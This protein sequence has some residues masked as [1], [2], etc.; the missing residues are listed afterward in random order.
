MLSKLHTTKGA[1]IIA[2]VMA[3]IIAFTFYGSTGAMFAY[4]A[5]GDDSKAAA[6]ELEIKNVEVL[7][8]GDMQSIWRDAV[9]QGDADKGEDAS[10]WYTTYREINLRDPRIFNL[11]YTVDAET[12]GADANAYLDKVTLQYGSFDLS[13]WGGGMTLRDTANPILILKDKKIAVNADGTYTVSIAME[14]KSAWASPSNNNKKNPEKNVPWDGYYSGRQFDFGKGQSADNRSWWQAGP[15]YK[16]C[17]TYALTANVDG[18]VVA[19]TDVHI[20]PYDEMKSWIEINEYAQSIVK[21]INGSEVPI[22]D[23]DN[24]ITGTVAKG[25]VAMDEDGNLVKGDRTDSVYVEVSVLG[26]GLTDNYKDENKDFNNYSRFNPIWNVAVAADEDTVDTYLNETK[27]TMNEDPQSLVDK[28]ENAADEDIDMINVYYQNN[29]HSDEVTGTETMIKLIGDLIE[30]GKAG[31]KINYRTWT[32]EDMDYRYRDPA[33]GATAGSTH[34]VKGGYDGIFM[35]QSKRTDKYIDTKEALEKLIFVSTLC[36]NPDGKAGMRRTNRYAFDLN[37]DAVFST[38]PETIAIIKDLMKWDP[39][40]M[41]EWHGYVQSMLIE[42][43]TA[44]HDPAFDYDLL[45][46]NM[47]NLSYA[48]GLAVTASSG[49]SNFLVPWD[50]YDGGDW[51]DGGTIYAPMFSELLGCYGFTIEFPYANSDSFDANNAVNY[52]MIDELLHGTTEF[53]DGNRLNGELKDVEGN[54]YDSHKVDIKYTSMRKSTVLSKL[55]TKL[56]GINNVDAKDK[57]DKYLIDKKVVDGVKEDRIVGRS[58]PVD[59]DGNELSFFPDYIVVPVDDETQYN[60]AEGIK[61]MNQMIGWNIK[62]DVSTSDVE[63]NGQTIKA[64][65]YVINMKQSNRNVI[66]EVMSKGYDAT[67]FSDM[68][69]DIYC[70]L[71]D[72]RGFD[73]IQVYGDGLFDGKTKT[74]DSSIVKEANISGAIDEYVVFKSQS[75]DAVRFVNLL[76]SGRSSGPSY[77]EKGDVWMLRKDVEGIGEA[78]D[79]II[80]VEDLNKIDNLKDNVNLGLNG[81]HIEGK[82]IA[83]LPEEAVKL[84]EPVISLNTTRTA[85]TGG[86]L[87]WMLDDYLGFGSMVDYNG[88]ASGVRDGAN[89]VIANSQNSL[90]ADILKAVKEDKAGLIMIRSANAL[91]TANFGL[92]FADGATAPKANS[93]ND[94]ALNGTYNVDDSIFTTNYATTGTYYARGSGFT[95]IPE[96]SKVLFQTAK[97]G[98]EAFIGGFQATQGSKESFADTNGIFSTILNGGGI[99]GKPVQALVIGQRIDYRPHYQKL[100]PLLA[101]GIYAG[102]AGILDDMNDPVISDFEKSGSTFTVK[103]E[104]PDSGVIE[105]GIEK[106]SVYLIK[107]G[108]EVLV[109]KS[110]TGTV[111]VKTEGTDTLKFKA[112]A[113]DYAGNK[114]VK[115]YTYRPGSESIKGDCDGDHQ[116]TEVVTPATM[117]ADGSAVQICDICEE[118]GETRAIAKIEK[119]ALDAAKATYKAGIAPVVKAAD[120]NGKALVEGTDYDVVCGPIETTGIYDVTVN[121]KGDYEGTVLL[122]FA[123]VPQK[124][125]TTVNLVAATGGYNDVKAKWTAVKGAVGYKVLYKK[126]SA[127]SWNYKYTTNTSLTV[128]D[129][130]S[131][132]KYQVKVVPYIKNAAGNKIYSIA[133][134]SIKSVYT[135]KKLTTPAVVKSGTAVKVKWTNIPGESGYQISKAKTKT[136]TNIVATVP[137]TTG[138]SKIVKAAKGTKYYYKVRAYKVVDGKKVYAPWSAAKAYTL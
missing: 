77:A 132:T 9:Y 29:V 23:L 104:E 107:D 33:E 120:A 74:L 108:K 64:G 72:V 137:T 67:N 70:N 119:V 95:V 93:Y 82:Y 121:F 87:W 20:G 37:R 122:K 113:V 129:L 124:A 53:F 62:V 57:V 43:C 81:C 44:P 71:P 42:P 14:T 125:T 55:E 8:H 135:L 26:Y 97:T 7:E 76:L 13:E 3:F 22:E 17:G 11:E 111:K 86:P 25:Y 138:T 39:L 106:L 117:D 68:Y 90:N 103:A 80:Q 40:V 45:Q 24:Q 52:G 115:T 15:A 88:T 110:A 98:E 84:V 2:V 35:D 41:D 100:L 31:K 66:F 1:R 75:T 48:A 136:G 59:A 4:A 10:K 32:N 38:M 58:R 89:V 130:A 28:Y 34:T 69:A 49:C 85:Q 91:N 73:S 114:T 116:F 30:G 126:A 112:V 118:T 12:V 83:E 79:Y 78:S 128:K 50:H 102:A 56:R 18:K 27:V 131:G 51:D 92:E 65:A 6:A 134:P 46:N 94:I 96:G 54:T 109:G 19:S 47:L 63:Y 60:V 16:G 99:E 123:V 101:T 133:T 61:A 127:S 105:S 36:S 5:S 21:A